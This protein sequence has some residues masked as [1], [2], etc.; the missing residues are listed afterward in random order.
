MFA[1][2]D[3]LVKQIIPE[4]TYEIVIKEDNGETEIHV[5]T[6]KEVISK[7]IGK[8]GRIAKSIRTI[9]RAAAGKAGVRS[10]LFIEEKV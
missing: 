9:V 2:V 1:L 4:G 5:V 10:S 3:F 8:Q 6:E 7:L